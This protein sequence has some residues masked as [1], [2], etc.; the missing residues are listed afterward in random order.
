MDLVNK[1]GQQRL[2]F[3]QQ[4]W[5]FNSVATKKTQSPKHINEDIH[6]AILET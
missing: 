4:Q 5:N 6:Q 1:N 2:R 3:I